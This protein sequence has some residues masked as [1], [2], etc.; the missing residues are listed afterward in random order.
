[1]PYMLKKTV[2]KLAN[3]TLYLEQ[4]YYLGN[5]YWIVNLLNKTYKCYDSFG[6]TCHGGELMTQCF[7]LCSD[8]LFDFFMVISN[9][10]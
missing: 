5:Y 1:M 6:C 4:N 8:C 7:E 2:P 10:V 9:G 3:G